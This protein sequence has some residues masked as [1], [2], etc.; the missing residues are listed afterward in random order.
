MR[1]ATSGLV[2]IAGLWLAAEDARAQAPAGAQPAPG[3]E[4]AAPAEPEP[5]RAE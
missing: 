4:A 3:S 1:R 5:A 2:L